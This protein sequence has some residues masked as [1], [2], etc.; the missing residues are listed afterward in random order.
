[1]D[2]KVYLIAVAGGSGTRMGG[3]VPKQ[4]MLLGGKPILRLTIEKFIEACPGI[5]V[6]TVLPSEHIGWWRNYCAEHNFTCPQTLVEGG[7][8]RF[9]S[10]KAALSKVPDGAVVMI[11]DGVR[12]FLSK[13]LIQKMLSLVPQTHGVIPVMPSTDTL[14]LLDK[15]S[16]GVLVPVEGETPDRSRIFGAQTPQVFRSEDIKAA[17]TQ[18]Y[19]QSFTDDESVARGIKIPLAFVE[20][21]RFNIK[22]TTPEDLVLAQAL[23]PLLPE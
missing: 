8:T 16:E 23:L 17:Y 11:H 12:P 13:G 7:F 14:K 21:E 9:H 4:F 10:V 2:R 18:P 15:S 19:S 5:K 1:M 6:V 20:G 3:P 22:I